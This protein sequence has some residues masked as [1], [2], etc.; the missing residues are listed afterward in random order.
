[1]DIKYRQISSLVA[2]FLISAVVVSCLLF[3]SPGMVGVDGYYHITIASIVWNEGLT[4]AFPYLE[5][6]L[7]D[8]AHYVD[9]HMLFHLLQSPFTAFLESETAAKLSATF[10][11]ACTFTLFTWL[12]RQYEVPYPLFWVL[13]LLILSESFLYRMMM[14][15]PPIFALAYTWLAFHCLMRRK[16]TGLAIVACLFAW[17]YKVFPILLPM[18]AIAMFVIYVEKK[19]IDVR[20]MLAVA[21][22]ITAGLIINPYFPENINFLWNAIQMKILSDSFQ[23]SVGN[24]WYPLKTLALLKDA[25][26]PLAAYLLGILLTNREEWRNDP[27]RLFWFLLSTMWLLMLFK[28]RR[29]IEFFPPAALL[30][31][32]FAIRPWLQQQSTQSV[33]E[34]ACDVVAS[35]GCGSPA[36]CRW[37]SHLA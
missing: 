25:A 30:F 12:L 27:A 33:A 2:A 28:S 35:A 10:F 11:I 24:E 7:L 6:T 29:F 26:I 9:M 21:V 32:I 16:Y 17:T 20:P 5:F 36:T 1:M 4:F 14:S 37:I 3:T 18:A 31:F 8:Q 22:G 15:R 13:L 23:A 19:E 34:A